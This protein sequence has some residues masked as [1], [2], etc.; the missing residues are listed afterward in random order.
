MNAQDMMRGL[1]IQHLR[2]TARPLESIVFGDQAGPALRGAVYQALSENF[3]SEPKGAFTPGH[4]DRCPVC[5]LMAAE[6]ITNG[7]GR[8]IPRPLTVEPPAAQIYHRGEVF[9]F[10]F[11]LIGKAQDLLP[12][13]VRAVQKMGQ[14]GVG[15][16]RGRFALEMIGEYSPLIDARRDLMQQNIVRAPTLQITPVRVAEHAQAIHPDRITLEVLTPMRL[17]ADGRL[18]REPHPSV[19]IQRLLERCESLAAR[20]AEVD[21]RPTREQ[22][23]AAMLDLK[24]RAQQLTVAYD[25][26]QWVDAWS[27]SR[28]KSYLTPIGGFVGVCRW[29]GDVRGLREWLLWGQSV[30]VG[31]DTV[32][33]NGWYRVTG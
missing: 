2:F 21:E 6:D 17:I 1:T 31:K 18:I 25:D 27:G 22:W 7:R 29:E 14:I 4:A 30:H 19:F 10:G 5:W 33:G 11:T 3:C 13:L 26:T 24:A 8:D 32:K 28:R 23:I 20:Y 16:G 9:D 12:Y 15:K